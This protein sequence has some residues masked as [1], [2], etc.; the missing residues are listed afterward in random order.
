MQILSENYFSELINQ[1]IQEINLEIDT[2][3]TIMFQDGF[4]TVECTW[5]LR[6]H[7]GVQIGKSEYDLKG[8]NGKRARKIIK[9]LLLNNQVVKIFFRFYKAMIQMKA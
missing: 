6:N 5:R 4:L 3:L 9:K 8:S 1:C 2:P 7:K